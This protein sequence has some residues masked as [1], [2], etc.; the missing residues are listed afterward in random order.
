MSCLL[1]TL[2]TC[3]KVHKSLGLLHNC[4]LGHE[5]NGNRPTDRQ[6]N[7]SICLGTAESLKYFRKSEIFTENLSPRQSL[8]VLFSGVFQKCLVGRSV[9]LYKRTPTS[10]FYRIFLGYDPLRL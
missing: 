1:V 7:L 2:I 9:G 5:G 4:Q 8:R 6:L 3:L 10:N